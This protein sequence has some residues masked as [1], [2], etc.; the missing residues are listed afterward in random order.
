MSFPNYRR[1]PYQFPLCFENLLVVLFHNGLES[2]LL[3]LLFLLTERE[4]GGRGKEGKSFHPF[5]TPSK[6]NTQGQVLSHTE[7]TREFK[8]TTIAIIIEDDTALT[9]IMNNINRL[10]INYVNKNSRLSRL[11]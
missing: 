5:H 3:L 9:N 6:T 8:K 11:W 1:K 10:I 2:Q 4:R 7:Y